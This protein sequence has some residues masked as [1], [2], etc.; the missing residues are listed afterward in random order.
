MTSSESLIKQYTVAHDLRHAD[1][2]GLVGC[3]D[4]RLVMPGDPVLDS[5]HLFAQLRGGRLGLGGL[6]L[7][8]EVKKPG[9]FIGLEVSIADFAQA[10]GVV[11]LM[12]GIITT[13]HGP[14]CGGIESATTI[15]NGVA[16]G[17]DD[18]PMYQNA[19][20]FNPSLTESKYLR[21]VEAQQRINAAGLASTP[22][23]IKA[24]LTSPS[25]VFPELHHDHI[26]PHVELQDTSHDEI[27]FVADYRKNVAF[28]RAAAHQ[29][30]YGAYYSSFGAFGEMLH[31]APDSITD[32]VTLEEWWATEAVILGRIN[33]HDITNDGTPYPV[34]VIGS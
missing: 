28:D 3:M 33:T 12:E 32:D 9:R 23:Q 29:A 7:A 14:N 4:R 21:V 20:R 6:A 8:L 13:K 24:A 2:R 19:L 17:K 15:G 11:L 26:T 34:E 5:D 22:R 1:G 27:R 10:M 18:E 31:A 30:G 25:I 16:N